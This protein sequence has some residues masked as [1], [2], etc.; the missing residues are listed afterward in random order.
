MKLLIVDDEDYTREG[1][2]D[3]IDWNQLQISDIMQARD[4]EMALKISRWFRPDIVLT[5]IRMPRMDGIAFARELTKIISN[6]KIIFM[7]GY[8]EIP[9]LQEAIS[10][11]AVS[12]I[13]KP[14]DKL[15]VIEAVKKASDDIS[16]ENSRKQM[17]FTNRELMK[18]QLVNVLILQKQEKEMIY[19]MCGE[20]GYPTEG[21]FVTILVY[22]KEVLANPEHNKKLIKSAF[23]HKDLS[24][25]CNYINNRQYLLVAAAGR[26]SASLLNYQC[27]VFIEGNKQFALGIG[28]TVSNIKAVYTSYESARMALNEVFYQPENGIFRLGDNYLCR[29]ALEPSLFTDFIKVFEENP[30][31]LRSWFGQ[32]FQRLYETRTFQKELVQELFISLFTE[33]FDKNHDLYEQMD[34][35]YSNDE[36]ISLWIKTAESLKEIQMLTNKILDC[37]EQKL[38]DNSSYSRVIGNIIEYISGHYQDKDLNMQVLADK[39]HFSSTYLT[40]LFKQETGMTIKQFISEY[41]IDRAKELLKKDFY[42][43]SE[44]SELCGYSTAAYFIKVFRES[45]GMTPAEYREHEM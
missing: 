33:I 23:E 2:V 26:E 41:R 17:S 30:F 15:K 32:L 16:E 4:G 12:F 14:L 19:R 22:E 21:S 38:E 44:I 13:E 6:C 31:G 28:F 3:N 34:N 5:D 40:I 45:V 27:K 18:E 20:I 39:Y 36:N 7:T 8:M 25:L 43:I 10:L 42:K 29:R 11:S 9:Y 37:L 24:L 35:M 1:L